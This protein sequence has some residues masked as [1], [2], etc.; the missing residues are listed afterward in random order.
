[1]SDNLRYK[2]R[3]HEKYKLNPIMK[4]KSFANIPKKL[5]LF[6]SNTSKISKSMN[7]ICF[8]DINQKNKDIINSREL[9]NSFDQKK[10]KETWNQLCKYIHKNYQKGKGTLIEGFG[11]F[12]FLDHVLN[13]EG[14]SNKNEKELKTKEPIFIV[15]K[16]FV[17][18]IKPAVFNTNYGLVPF[19]QKNYNIINEKKINYYEIAKALNISKDEC[20]QIIK[21]IIH[22]M[23][24]QIK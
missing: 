4:K 18:F 20:Y 14:T 10:T 7:S 22:D 16:E 5:I 21:N 9:F 23:K 3:N 8:S 19:K 2:N 1:M 13:L 24:Q 15:S 6:R 11:T 17:Q 12:T